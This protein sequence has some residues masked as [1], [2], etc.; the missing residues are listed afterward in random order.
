MEIISSTKN[1]LILQTKKI[2]DNQIDNKVFLDGPKII[3]EAKKNNITI[4]YVLIDASIC[5]K[6]FEQYKFLKDEKIVYVSAAIIQSLS[7]T[8][9][10]QG[11]VAVALME[12]KV[13]EKPRSNFLVL[14]NLQDPG[15]VGTIIRSARGTNFK[16]IYLINCANVFGQKVLRSTMGSV[17]AT[18]L[19]LFKSTQE[20]C[21]FA[22][23]NNFELYGAELEGKNI[24]EVKTLPGSNFGIV[25]GNEGNGLTEEIKERCKGFFTIPMKN[26][27]ESLNASVACSIVMYYLDNLKI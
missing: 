3:E 26:N 12:P 20:F 10:P 9:T 19:Y 5:E 7:L 18:N 23:K 2:R 27:L 22:L 15:N 4:E 14:E 24:F 16:D 11:I 13:P 17:F 6:I 21:E 25:I 8:K 1:S